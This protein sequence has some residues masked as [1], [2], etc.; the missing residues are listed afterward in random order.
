VL[1]S[2]SIIV[3]IMISSIYGLAQRTCAT[4]ELERLNKTP[5]QLQ[6]QRDYFENW[7]ETKKLA[8]F[9]TNS[10]EGLNETIIYKI[11]VVVHIIHRGEPVGFGT[12][13]TDEQV[14]AQI[15]ALNLDFRHLN[16]DSVNTPANFQPLMADTGFEFVLAKSDP[17]GFKTNG[18]TRTDGN[19][20]E[21]F[22]SN[23]TELKALSY[24]D[25]E[26]YLNIWVAPLG[27]YLGWAEFPTSTII[28]GVNDQALNNPLTDGVV[29]STTA[30]GSETLYPQGEYNSRFNQGRTLTHELG[31]FFGLR[32]VW[33]DGGCSADDYV[34]DTPNTFDSYFNCPLTGTSEF[35]CNDEPSMFMNYMD[36][37]DDECMNLFT[38][39]Q[40]DRMEIVL[41]NSPRRASLMVSPGLA[42]PPPLDLAI[43]SIVSP[44]LSICS[45]QFTPQ[46]EVI[47]NGTAS[48]NTV[49]ASFMVNNLTII[50]KEF[51]FN[52][53]PGESI[54]LVFDD[55]SFVDYGLYQ[56]DYS[57]LTVNNGQ[58]DNIENNQTGLQV[59]YNETV[60]LLNEE[61]T[62][63][64]QSW[65]VRSSAPVSQWNLE[66]AP[67][68]VAE[69][70][71]VVL[72]Y[73]NKQAQSDQLYLPIFDL[74][75]VSDASFI[76]DYAYAN[77][78]GKEDQLAVVISTDCG[79][80]FADTLFWKSGDQLAMESTPVKFTPSGRFDWQ[81]VVLDLSAY[82]NQNV[83]LA[84]AGYS[85]GGNN[86]Y[87]DNFHLVD[88][89]YTDIGII[90]LL[91]QSGAFDNNL[92]GFDLVVA[93]HGTRTVSDFDVLI[94]AGSEI[95][96]TVSI[97]GTDLAPMGYQEINI[98]NNFNPGTSNLTFELVADDQKLDNNQIS[99]VIN[100]L[101][102]QTE[103][104]FREN[105]ISN[106]FNET[107]G[108]TISSL[109]DENS[110]QY[111]NGYLKLDIYSS[112]NQGLHDWLVLPQMDFSN[113]TE[114]GLRFK[115]AYAENT[116]NN[117]LL[118]IWV[119]D[120]GGESFDYLVSEFTGLEIA[121]AVSGFEWS[122]SS[123]DDW[124]SQFIDLS[125]F[126][127]KQTILIGFETT[128][129]DGNNIYLDDIE[130][131]VS[132]DSDLIE[133]PL[134]EVATY[135]NP[136][137]DIYSKITFNLLDKQDIT[138]RIL[139]VRG[140]VIST[141]VF[142]NVLNQTY[143]LELG[144]QGNGIYF[145]DATGSSFS[146]TLRVL[147]NR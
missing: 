57:I 33:G 116:F 135:P 131:F 85:E 40:K 93:N 81:T 43:T 70:T 124:Q 110:W 128:D 46:L 6:E 108:W 82:I 133:L 49:T 122:P 4:D 100:S 61:F 30:F 10:T 92:D 16:P 84:F 99:L 95:V 90:G 17:L 136:I 1:R 23:N 53:G 26:D 114:A 25:T 60:T 138:V 15:E 32:H 137:T 45:N 78:V 79:I 105:F 134:D 86:I 27:D 127:G 72:N 109:G 113:A 22:F 120:N 146:N 5:Q 9:S 74:T 39:E 34:I 7:I 121:T 87:L 48:I 18:I 12:N 71:A 145:V 55:Y 88:N 14:F 28:P 29:V 19:K 56:V 126:A 42:E 140:Q 101:G 65:A 75:G 130:L 37:V 67:N 142:E 69:N 63:F 62:E 96:N 141:Q 41:T 104:P 115:V 47:N 103:I 147:V 20:E 24:W 8:S 58:D 97:S 102:E 139:D 11:P 112:G 83:Q 50:E 38:L 2:F 44:E 59:A 94:K 51:T 80:N 123:D 125:N 144:N 77:R 13:I 52:L 73:F 91:N 106:P 129:G 68:L 31:H 54:L 76:F 66:V 132:G 119:S 64:P 21:W 143:P 98:P 118:R 111:D 3:L 89:N 117:E 35:S 36:Y 107:N